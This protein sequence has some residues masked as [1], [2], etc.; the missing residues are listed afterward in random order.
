[1]KKAEKEIVYANQH[2]LVIAFA[3]GELKCLNGDIFETGDGKFICING[4]FVRLDRNFSP[5]LTSLSI[6][7]CLMEP[8]AEK[9]LLFRVRRHDQFSPEGLHL[10]PTYNVS[11]GNGTQKLTKHRYRWF[12]VKVGTNFSKCMTGTDVPLVFGDEVVL[13]D[14]VDGL[15]E[16]PSVQDPTGYV[17]NDFVCL[18]YSEIQAYIRSKRE[19]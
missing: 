17:Q 5:I 3:E 13:A 19:E 18:H 6:P 4:K 14:Y 11:S 12:I 1:M 8:A 2:E 9:V 15:A 7:E 16:L 10:A